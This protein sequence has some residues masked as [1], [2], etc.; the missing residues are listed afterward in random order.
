VRT[1]DLPSGYAVDRFKVDSV[2]TSVTFSPSGD[3]LATSHVHSIGICLWANRTQY[4]NVLLRRVP[5]EEEIMNVNMPTIQAVENDDEEENDSK[6]EADGKAV[7][8]DSNEE[9]AIRMNYRTPEQL[10]DDLVTLSMEPKSKWQN[11]LNLETIKVTICL[12]YQ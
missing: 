2:A 3:F 1:W 6:N 11:L 10:A 9:P 8:E 12:L 5:D 7:Q 4:T